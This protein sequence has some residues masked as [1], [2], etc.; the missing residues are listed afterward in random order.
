M[1]LD[2]KTTSPV[3]LLWITLILLILFASIIASLFISQYVIKSENHHYVQEIQHESHN[4]SLLIGALVPESIVEEDVSSLQKIVGELIKFQDNIRYIQILNPEARILAH[5]GNKSLKADRSLSIKVPIIVSEQIVGMLD[6][7]W[8]LQS[9]LKRSSQQGQLIGILSGISILV[10]C[11]LLLLTMQRWAVDPL[12]SFNRKLLQSEQKLKKH[13]NYLEQQTLEKNQQ[14]HKLSQVVEQSHNAI[15]ITDLNANIEFVNPAFSQITGYTFA[16]AFQKNPN[17][18]QFGDHDSL[19]YPMMWETLKRGEVWRGELHNKHKDGHGFW[20]YS[21]ISPIKD[22]ANQIT[23]YVAVNEDISK[24][25]AIEQS[26]L[27]SQKLQLNILD[28][29]PGLLWV[30]NIEGCYTDCNLKFEKF[31]G[32]SKADIIGKKDSDFFPEDIVQ[33]FYQQ[34]KEVIEKDKFIQS[35]ERVPARKGGGWWFYDIRKSPMK[36]LDGIVFG[37]IGIARDIT[38]QH[39]QQ[40]KLQE[41]EKKYRILFEKSDDAIL[42]IEDHKFVDCNQATVK[43]LGYK[44]KSEVI[45]CHPCDLSLEYQPDG[46]LSFEKAEEMMRIAR[47]QGS[48]HFEWVHV[49]ADGSPF[50]VLVWLTSIPWQG[51]YIC[52]VVWRDMT[53]IKRNEKLLIEARQQAETANQAKSEFLANMSHEIRTPMN[54]II[55]MS[56]LAL[57]GSLA[58]REYNFISKVH[59]AAESLLSI[60]NDILD[61]S[62]IEA[63]KLEID[64]IDFSLQTVLDNLRSLVGLKAAEKGLDLSIEVASEIPSVLKGDPLRIGQILT[65]LVNNAVKFTSHGSISIQIQAEQQDKQ[66]LLQ[67]CVNDTGIGISQQQQKKLFYPFSQAEASTTR[68]FGGTGLGLVIC[69]KLVKLM[70]GSIWVDSELWQGTR[71]SFT[72]LLQE[73]DLDYVK[74]NSR[75]NDATINHLRGAQILLVEDNILNQELASELLRSKG[76]YVTT[77]NNGKEALEVLVHKTFDGILMDVQMPIMGGY[78]ATREIRRQDQYKDIPII[79]MTA[80]MMTG[81]REKAEQ[82]GMNDHIGKPLE[83]K[84]MFITLAKWIH[85]ESITIDHPSKGNLA[86]KSL[87]ECLTG[88][89]KGIDSVK[90]LSICQNNGQRYH[91]LLSQFYKQ[92]SRFYELFTMVLQEDDPQAAIQVLRILKTAAANIAAFPIQTAANKLE[93]L[94]E[95]DKESDEAKVALQQLMAQL[96]PVLESLK[97]LL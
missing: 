21:T 76:M 65:N 93:L 82:A 55:G 51:D 52:H 41:S 6:I 72:V 68:R 27:E 50:P 1:L 56:Q 40:L 79:A 22:E 36:T 3:S 62:R 53:E 89:D 63:D 66:I 18:L 60:I 11:F 61:F 31:I 57:E 77:V 12:F 87:D 54:V 37:V 45:N 30:K 5:A 49:R 15:I 13:K 17:I 43:M 23:H 96:N 86:E 2:K 97:C 70:G 4:V 75:L 80:N 88:I 8:D 28:T 34:D 90:G 7:Y 69:K 94:C 73:G 92:Q 46:C 25:K 39:H 35:D 19:F 24:R 44:D 16:E 71:V 83:I 29:M 20:E 47:E 78:E 26:L 84:Q 59:H 95:Q 58:P 91:Q 38:E 14:L 10:S 64:I 42:I 48:N 81:D 33:R 9:L 74:K 85:A 32:R 67:F